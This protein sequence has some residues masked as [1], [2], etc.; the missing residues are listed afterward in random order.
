MRQKKIK[1][2]KTKIKKD[3]KDFMKDE[4]GFM[5][6]ENILKVGLGTVAAL[7]MFSGMAH[8]GVKPTCDDGS[9]LPIH[10]SDNTVQWVDVGGR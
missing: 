5:T 3:L 1:S 4:S 8:G 2:L 9:G 7:S 10:T 6:K